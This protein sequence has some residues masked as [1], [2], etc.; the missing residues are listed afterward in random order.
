MKRMSYPDLPQGWAINAL[1]KMQLE[2]MSSQSLVNWIYQTHKLHDHHALNMRTNVHIIS[3][4]FNFA[5][6]LLFQQSQID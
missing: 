1:G 2:I 4:I 6:A 3:H 5:N